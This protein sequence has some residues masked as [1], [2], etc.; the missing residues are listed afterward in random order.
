MLY[1]YFIPMFM[2][3]GPWA[4]NILLLSMWGEIIFPCTAGIL[5]EATQSAVS[6]TNAGQD[7]SAGFIWKCRHPRGHLPIRGGESS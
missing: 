7:A 3:W 5:S 6:E 2:G 1:F 4:L